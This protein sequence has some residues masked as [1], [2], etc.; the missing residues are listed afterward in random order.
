MDYHWNVVQKSGIDKSQ[1]QAKW[2]LKI[3][4]YFSHMMKISDELLNDKVS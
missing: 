4:K 2:K 3:E 1:I